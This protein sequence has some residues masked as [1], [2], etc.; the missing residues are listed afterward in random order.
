MQLALS[1]FVLVGCVAERSFPAPAQMCENLVSTCGERRIWDVPG[2]QKCFE[3]GRSGVE[4]SRDEDQCFAVHD[5]C[6]SDCNFWRSV[7]NLDAGP[8]DAGSVGADA[9]DTTAQ[10]VDAGPDT[11]TAGD[12]STR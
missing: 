12:A 5:E 9:G 11:T 2:M 10:S 4:D 3:I 8:L 1:A 6:I 7:T